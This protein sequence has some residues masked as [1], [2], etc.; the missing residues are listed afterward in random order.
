MEVPN[1]LEYLLPDQLERI[2]QVIDKLLK[3][4]MNNRLTNQ[5]YQK[6]SIDIK[7]P[8]FREKKYKKNGHKNGTQRYLCKICHKSF[9]ITT[10]TLLSYSKINYLQLKL[11]IK[12]ILESK[13]VVEISYELNMSQ[14]QIYYLEMKL[15]SA[16]DEVYD[17]VKLKGVVQADEKYFR[18][19][20]K[21]TKLNK[22]PRKTRHSGTQDL[23]I[24]I[25]KELVCVVLAI[26]EY[27]NIVIKV[28]GNGPASSK[29]ISKALDNKI[30]EGSILVTDSKRG[31]IK[32]ALDNNLIL[33][34]IPD[35]E[36]TVEGIYNLSEINELILELETYITY[37]KKGVSTKHLQQYCNFIKYRKILK[38]TYEFLERNEEMYKTT[39][40]LHSTITN[41]NVCKLELPFDVTDLFNDY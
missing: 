17:D 16:L 23:K 34:Q 36:Y 3:S 21:G 32:F 24:G 19:S 13:P 11:F 20:F 37:Y 38:Y 4:K 25:N 8:K 35:G 18:I 5:E 27:D 40:G 41:A 1:E 15:F 7:C 10:N 31:Y 22:M 33:K 39:I 29:M 9:S 28:V 30:V 14:T 2:K 6:N 12:C 26:D